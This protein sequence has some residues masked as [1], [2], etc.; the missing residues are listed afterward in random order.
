VKS[1]AFKSGV[2]AIAAAILVP[3]SAGATTRLMTFTGTVTPGSVGIVT[4]KPGFTQDTRS[5]AGQPFRLYVVV[6]DDPEYGVPYVQNFQVRWSTR[7]LHEYPDFPVFNEYG[8][9]GT[10]YPPSDLFPRDDEYSSEV[11]LTD[12]GGSMHFS[13]F[14]ADFRY[15]ELQFN[16]TLSS[17]HDPASNF[18]DDEVSGGGTFSAGYDGFGTPDMRAF[19]G[20]TFDKV[21]VTGPVPEPAA[22]ALM[23]VGFTGVGIAIRGPASRRRRAC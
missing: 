21:S 11:H 14:R 13:P 17:P 12:T 6:A 22:W 2:V 19:G 9:G 8:S 3:A 23:L 5:F 15:S 16:F 18:V 10:G 7:D 4:Y 20:Y 1:L